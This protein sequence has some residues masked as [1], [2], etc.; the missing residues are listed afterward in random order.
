MSNNIN[1]QWLS[2]QELA[3]RYKLPVKTL[4]QW[5]SMGTGPRY[6]RMGRH[7]RYRLSDIADWE[8]ER[9]QDRQDGTERGAPTREAAEPI[10]SAAPRATDADTVRNQR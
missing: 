8:A 6:A 2:R 4:A 7:V 3:D 1:E 10:A 9:I 5:A